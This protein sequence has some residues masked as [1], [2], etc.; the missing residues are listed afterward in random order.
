MLVLS[1][2]FHNPPDR[3]SPIPLFLTTVNNLKTFVIKTRRFLTPIVAVGAVGLAQKLPWSQTYEPPASTR[4]VATEFMEAAGAPVFPDMLNVG[5]GTEDDAKSTTSSVVSE[6]S[7]PGSSA[8]SPSL[9]SLAAPPGVGAGV[10]GENNRGQFRVAGTGGVASSSPLSAR[11]GGGSSY[12]TFTGERKDGAAGVIDFVHDQEDG[13][14]D[15]GNLPAVKVGRIPLQEPQ[16]EDVTTALL[17]ALVEEEKGELGE[18]SDIG[19][20]GDGNRTL[21]S[22]QLTLSSALEQEEGPPSIAQ[23]IEIVNMMGQ[24]DDGTGVFG[25]MLHEPG[26]RCFHLVCLVTN[27]YPVRV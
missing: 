23:E 6:P 13:T 8:A 27:Y 2:S 3:R 16:S 4:I 10:G 9:L 5:L 24:E 1:C 21:K 15:V 25:A 18:L 11:G 26:E 20:G 14:M 7:P 12:G 17:P 19:S 22:R